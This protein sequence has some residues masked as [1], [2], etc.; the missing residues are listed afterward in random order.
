MLNEY[1]VLLKEDFFFII[2]NEAQCETLKKF[3][4]DC[5][6]VDKTHG[7]NNYDFKLTTVLVLVEMKQ[8]FPCAFILS[9]RTDTSVIEIILK[10]SERNVAQ[11]LLRFSCLIS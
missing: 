7:I 5:I 11:F 9:N 1:L 8:R 6:C 2:M 10:I 4:S 3:G